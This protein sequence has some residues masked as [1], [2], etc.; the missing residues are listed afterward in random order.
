MMMMM[1]MMMMIMM[2]RDHDDDNDG[3]SKKEILPK[4]QRTQGIGYFGSFTTFTIVQSRT[5]K[6][7]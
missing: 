2:K 4:A 6:K 3:D 5:F 7:L 1:M